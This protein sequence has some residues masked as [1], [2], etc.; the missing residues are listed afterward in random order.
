MID[1]VNISFL[2]VG[3][4]SFRGRFEDAPSSTVFT[5]VADFFQSFKLVVANL[6]S[7]LVADNFIPVQGKCTL[8]GNVGWAR[9]MKETGFDLVSIANNH[10]MD[11]GEQGLFST[12]EALNDAGIRYVGAGEN[13][14]KARDP[15]FI[16]IGAKKVGF[17]GR[18]SVEV[19]SPCYAGRNT[20]GVAFLDTE[21]LLSSIAMCRKSA[22]LVVVM[23]HWG[24]EHYLYPS[25]YQR[26]L[27]KKIVSA[28]AHVIL[29]HHPHVLQGEEKIGKALISYSSGN[30]LFDEFFWTIESEDGIINEFQT[31]LSQPNREGLILQVN[32]KDDLSIS[33]K[34]VFT[35]INENGTIA[36]DR[37]PK[38]S[39]DYIKIGKKL[40][41][42][43]YQYFW[44]A[45]SAKRE[46]DLR[47]KS[48]FSPVRFIKKFYKIRP[49]HFKELFTSLRRSARVSSEK[50]TNPYD[51]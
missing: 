3:D 50:S 41:I 32:Q 13:A 14:Q 27:A 35:L 31:K 22:D 15:A 10:I 34:K 20:P 9:V 12:I 39:K 43:L 5:S 19:S 48:I 51:G 37:S 40:N 17:L 11:F 30:F 36:L 47:L 45:Y 6:E 29:G 49:R 7:P 42:P 46:W 24:L 38:R 23:L 25:P 1:P 21:E 28:G 44:K 16:E 4:V 26:N 18:S 33:S 2:S 8:R